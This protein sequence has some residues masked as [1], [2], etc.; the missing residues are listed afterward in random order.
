VGKP[1]VREKAT[2]QREDSRRWRLVIFKSGHLS[3]YWEGAYEP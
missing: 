1:Q 3:G 2:Y